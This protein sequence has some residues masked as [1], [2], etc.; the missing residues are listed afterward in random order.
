MKPSLSVMKIQ[1]CLF[2]SVRKEVFYKLDKRNMEVK[3]KSNEGMVDATIEMV[4][5]VMV[6]SP[7][8]VKFEP[9]DGDVITCTNSVC[10]YTLILKKV[11]CNIAYSYAVL[12]DNRCLKTGDWSSYKNPRPATEE[13][14]QK[15]F[16]ALADEGYAWDADKRELVKLKWKPKLKGIYYAP[17][18][19]EF[20][21]EHN[22]Y[23]WG[24]DDIDSKLYE[25]GWVF[26][27]PKEC[28][29]FCDRLNKAINQVKP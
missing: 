3:I 26:K 18:V 5:G 23:R 22:L 15:L 16:K 28:Q 8:E 2:V 20:R 4:D 19:N 24:K 1:R 10:S 29:E 13:E 14:K 12:L 9:K 25:M 17:S 11:E 7:K 6:V 27:T 21:F